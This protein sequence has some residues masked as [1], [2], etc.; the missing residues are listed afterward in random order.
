MK[1]KKLE[2]ME[3]IKD[4]TPILGDVRDCRRI[5]QDVK[6]G[7]YNWR[8]FEG[9]D[10]E[11]W[12]STP[13]STPSNTFFNCVAIRYAAL[14]GLSLWGYGAYNLVKDLAGLVR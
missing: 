14:G 12:A 1:H 6:D 10:P 4:F 3:L 2:L 13:S 8:D 9:D 5:R 11:P 7:F